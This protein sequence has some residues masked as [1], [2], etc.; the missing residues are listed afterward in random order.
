MKL[1]GA[2]R[3]CIGWPTDY[4]RSA[5][6]RALGVVVIQPYDYVDLTGHWDSDVLE[7]R[8]LPVL[9]FLGGADKMTIG[10]RHHSPIARGHRPRMQTIHLRCIPSATSPSSVIHQLN[11]PFQAYRLTGQ[12]FP[13]CCAQKRR[14]SHSF[15]YNRVRLHAKNL[16]TDRSKPQVTDMTET[17]I[18]EVAK[19]VWIFSK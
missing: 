7:A 9:R 17:V 14:I 10:L 1:G 13:P 8:G 5:A 15:V 19:D 2:L 16:S 12:H 11:L 3:A 18:R 4:E 6:T